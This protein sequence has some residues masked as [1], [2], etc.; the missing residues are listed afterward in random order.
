M[1]SRTK[2]ELNRVDKSE[3]A[4]GRHRWHSTP[5]VQRGGQ[6][7]FGHHRRGGRRADRFASGWRARICPTATPVL[8]APGD[9]IGVLS[10]PDPVGE[11]LVLPQI[12]PMADP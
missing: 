11:D 7:D 12:W 8:V 4:S 5:G 1:P 3:G 6:F 2:A 10:G 9:H